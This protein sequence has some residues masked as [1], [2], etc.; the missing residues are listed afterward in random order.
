ML[1]I[2]SFLAFI[3][4]SARLS[5][6]CL[7][8]CCEVSAS[9]PKWSSLSLGLAPLRAGGVSNGSYLFVTAMFE[10]MEST[11][12]EGASPKTAAGVRSLHS[13]VG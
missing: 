10:R 13:R 12:G 4:L 6:E 3:L 2:E 7:L 9:H 11:R 5:R 1:G 8:E